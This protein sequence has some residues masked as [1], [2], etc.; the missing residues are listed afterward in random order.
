MSQRAH[1]ATRKRWGFA[2]DRDP[3]NL[4]HLRR[5]GRGRED[6]TGCANA[7]YSA[8]HGDPNGGGVATHYR[9]DPRRTREGT[10]AVKSI[11]RQ[12][13]ENRPVSENRKRPAKRWERTES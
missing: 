10:S 5:A 6:G 12:T 4:D 1:A 8:R 3:R 7:V 11:D 2:L 13:Q 9:R